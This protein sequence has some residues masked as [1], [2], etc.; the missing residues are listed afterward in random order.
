MELSKLW[1]YERAR[2]YLTALLNLLKEI[3]FPDI[4]FNLE[5]VSMKKKYNWK[6]FL[7]IQEN[8]LILVKGI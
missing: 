4:L 5:F 3:H 1:S 2:K 7:I 8:T 6:S